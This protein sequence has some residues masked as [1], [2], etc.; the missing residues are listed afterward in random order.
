[1]HYHAPASGDEVAGEAV[2]PYLVGVAG[3]EMQ[4]G[5][6][7]PRADFDGLAE[8]GN[9]HELL[10]IFCPAEE[11]EGVKRGEGEGGKER[12]YGRGTAGN[13]CSHGRVCDGERKGSAGA[14]RSVKI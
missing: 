2:S 12:G 14:H 10:L 3:G 6:T 5:G 13:A 4:V 8:R 11:A 7:V 9:G 1:M